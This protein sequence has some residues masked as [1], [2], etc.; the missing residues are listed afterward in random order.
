MGTTKKNIV[1]DIDA[2]LVHTHGELD[3]F[4]MLKVYDP[5]TQMKLRKKVYSMVL[6]DVSSIPGE[7]EVT[8]LSGIYR[9]YLKE[10]LEFCFQ[11]FDNVV[12]WSAGKKKYVEK[13]CEFMFPLKH[14]PLKIFNYD[15]C[16]IDENDFIAK[17]LEKLYKHKTCKGKLNSKNTL[18]IDDRDDTF[19]LNKRNGILIPEFE[20]DMSIEDIHNHSDKN[21][22]KLIAWLST[23]EV[24]ESTDVKK[25]N[26]SNI[27]KT[28]LKE[29]KDI[30]KKEKSSSKNNLKK[31]K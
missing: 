24:S 9:P 7:G 4:K 12:I 25:L 22:L 31:E 5:Q 28:S 14:Q 2:T 16:D 10:F 30:L 13:M 11:Y 18:V 15:D 6:I 1:L 3:H 23:K 27:F 21:L 19:S 20:S 29:Y 26:K 17:P 8:E